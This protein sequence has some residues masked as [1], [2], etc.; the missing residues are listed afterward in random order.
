MP[1]AGARRTVT[2][3][4]LLVFLD[5]V[6]LGLADPSVNPL[7]AAHLPVLAA[8]LD[9][10]APLASVAPRTTARA[11][12]LGLDATLGVPGLPQSG[13]GQAALLTG[14][15]APRLFG[16]HFGPWVPTALRPLVAER[17]VMAR[18]AAAGLRV[19][20][21]NA[22]P[23]ELRGSAPLGDLSRLRGPLRAGPPLAA[24]GAGVLTRHGAELERGD[25]LA[26]EIVNDGWIERLG[27][28]ALPRVTPAEAGRRLAAIAASH[29][30]T[31]FAHYTTDYVG[32]RG[33]LED[34]LRV[35]ERV[36]AFIGG[37]LDALPPA[38]LLVVVSDHG[39]I[40]DVR[41]Q[42]TRNPALALLTGAGQAECAAGLR[43][44]TDVAPMLLRRLGVG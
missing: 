43:S 17:S 19:A 35:L 30:L 4:A 5:G 6:G 31:L 40:E 27:R 26:S 12:L 3:P 8:L 29:D 20:F 32:H 22:I 1:A 25:A 11:T 38:E 41:M 44:L 37:L 7:A 34:A 36:D 24:L 42:H 39:N 21:A 10:A 15:N 33:G 2:A 16:R 14:E 23:E 13:T 18:A 28:T 9:G